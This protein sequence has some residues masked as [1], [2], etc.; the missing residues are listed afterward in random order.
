MMGGWFAATAAGDYLVGVMGSFWDKLSL[1]F[2][3]SVLVI[4]CLISAIVIF[5]VMKRLQKATT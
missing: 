2:F 3:W 4:C 5:S 1:W